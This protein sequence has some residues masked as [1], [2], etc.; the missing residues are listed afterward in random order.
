[1]PM[2]PLGVGLTT[3]TLAKQWNVKVRLR[4]S[5]FLRMVFFRVGRT[6]I[7]RRVPYGKL[8]WGG[9]FLQ[10]TRQTRSWNAPVDVAN[11]KQVPIACCTPVKSQCIALNAGLFIGESVYSL[12]LRTR[13]MLP[14]QPC[15]TKIDQIWWNVQTNTSRWML[16]VLYVSMQPSVIGHCGWIN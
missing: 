4:L 9:F 12:F 13:R 11:S 5:A 8:V 14:H 1:M 6:G 7:H 3:Y 15:A 10:S 2:E 16:C